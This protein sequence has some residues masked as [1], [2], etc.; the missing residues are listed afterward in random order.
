MSALLRLLGPFIEVAAIVFLTKRLKLTRTLKRAGAN[1]PDRAIPLETSGLGNWWLHR[2]GAAG[3]IKQTPGGLY[4][5]DS[6]AHAEYRRVRVIRVALVLGIAFVL[7]VVWTRTCC[8][9]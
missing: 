4:W 8:G 5:L 2:L 1:A 7:W 6:V 3:V 9:P